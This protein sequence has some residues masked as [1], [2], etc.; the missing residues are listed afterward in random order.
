MGNGIESI[1]DAYVRIGDVAALKQIRD[2]RLGL[3]SQSADIEDLNVALWRERRENCHDDIKAVQKGIN[4]L[5]RREAVRGYVDTF[6]PQRIH[7]WAQYNRHLD[8]P[9]ALFVYFDGELVAEV[10]ADKYRADLKKLGGNGNHSFTFV[11]PAEAFL[12][13]KLIEVRAPNG[14]KLGSFK[15]EKLPTGPVLAV[16]PPTATASIAASPQSV[17]SKPASIPPSST[18]PARSG[19]PN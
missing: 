13:A 8:L 5:M 6:S 2:H 14:V 19:S 17:A 16:A 4:C 7:G 12:S 1:V 10:L 11:P 3:L 15:N 9:V 18:T